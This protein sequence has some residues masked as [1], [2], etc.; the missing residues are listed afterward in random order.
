M[1]RR[2][3][4]ARYVLPESNDFNVQYA[5]LPVPIDINHRAAFWGQIYA[6]GSARIWAND[7]THAAIDAAGVWQNIAEQVTFADDCN[8]FECPGGIT[9]EIDPDDED[10]TSGTIHDVATW[11]C[12]EPNI[13]VY[14][15]RVFGVPLGFAHQGF[16]L[17]KDGVTIG[18]EIPVIRV[19]TFGTSPGNH[20]V[21]T[22][23][24]CL[25]NVDSVDYGPGTDEASF[26]GYEVTKFSVETTDSYF[27]VV[28]MP[29][30]VLCTPA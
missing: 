28:T 4:P 25:G 13:D 12:P 23:S 8:P 19:M 16:R 2:K 6:L 30:E 22:R 17:R 3:P 18:A 7:D 27:M 24:D 5:C 14:I 15:A 1:S 21:F 26:D 29:H 9:L 20:I 11:N 10:N